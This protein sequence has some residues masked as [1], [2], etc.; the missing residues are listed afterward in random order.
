MLICNGRD[1]AGADAV[2]YPAAAAG[3]P[4]ADGAECSSLL[5]D[6]GGFL[7]LAVGGWYGSHLVY[8]YG[9]GRA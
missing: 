3:Q 1:V 5:L 4:P 2:Y 9:V 7:V 6:T 8:G